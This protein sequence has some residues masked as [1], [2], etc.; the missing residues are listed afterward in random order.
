MM[1]SWEWRQPRAAGLSVGERGGDLSE[2][3]GD[4][5]PL[6]LVE[7]CGEV[8][9]HAHVER[10]RLGGEVVH[11][12]TFAAELDHLE[13][14]GDFARATHLHLPPVQVNDALFKSGQRLAQRHVQV[15]VEVVALALEAAMPRDAHREVDIA[16]DLPGCL[17]AHSFK[18][19]LGPVRHSS[20][21]DRIQL[22]LLALAEVLG[23]HLLLLLHHEPG[24][25]LSLHQAR[26]GRAPCARRALGVELGSAGAEALAPTADNPS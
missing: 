13:R 23:G 20:L 24:R 18:G 22:R 6:R 4:D 15:C 16:R 11:G 10:A 19:E 3:V 25:H 8:H 2:M 1:R 5:L 26:L 17:L 14:L 9:E 7:V 12:H 21:D